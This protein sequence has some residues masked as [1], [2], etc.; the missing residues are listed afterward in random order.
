[1]P[2][3]Y[4]EMAISYSW[5][6]AEDLRIPYSGG[7]ESYRV[8][9][10]FD[11]GVAKLQQFKTKTLVKTVTDPDTEVALS[12]LDMRFITVYIA[13]LWDG[14]ND[15]LQEAMGSVLEQVRDK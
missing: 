10:L 12:D 2:S 6:V 8:Y 9:R 5:R 1:M 14:P 15:G 7:G 11:E 4:S 3:E 13:L